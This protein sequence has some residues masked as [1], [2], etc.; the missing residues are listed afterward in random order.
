MK[1]KNIKLIISCG[2][3]GGHIFPALEIAKSLK[4]INS[5]VDILF[6]GARNKMEMNKVPKAGFN[7]IGLWI[8]G[9]YR[10]AIFKNILFPLKLIISLIHSFFIIIQFR[11]NAIIGTGGFASGPVLFVATFFRYKTYIQEQNC[12]AGL[13][14]K[15][16]SNRVDKIFVAYD[17]MSLFFPINKTI[18]FGNPVRSSLITK[19]NISFIEK[20]RTFFNLSNKKFTILIIGGSLGAEPINKA[21]NYHLKNL[22]NED[23]QLIWQ[24][25]ERDFN[26]YKELHS[27][28]CSVYHFIDRM[29]LA[30]AAAD[31]VISR[32]GAIAIAEI[33]MLSKASILIPSPY[34]ADDHQTVN[35]MY[36]KENDA[37]E[38]MTEQQLMSQEFVAKILSFRSDKLRQKIGKNAHDL[39]KYDAANN[40][41]KLILED[42]LC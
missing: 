30:Y 28:N 15:I 39:F 29:D 17:D 16:L 35:A 40:I 3:T 1:K 12:F 41:A 27:K 7:I 34:V 11:P 8:Q 21:M 5:D 23:C 42:C 36:L 9:W 37:C 25:G 14:N 32:S 4:K 24:T 18:N 38:L 6:V 22:L 20:S 13:T 2:G 26:N 33:S 19:L 31:L 10:N